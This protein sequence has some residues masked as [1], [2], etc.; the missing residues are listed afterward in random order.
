LVEKLSAKSIRWV[1]KKGTWE[2][3]DWL[4]RK[5]EG[6]EEAITHGSRLEKKLNIDPDD[7][8]MNPKLHEM[9]TLTELDTH[10]QKL[11]EKG[12]GALNLFLAEKYI[13]YMSPFAA[14]ILTCMGVIVSSRKTRGGMGLQVALGF[15][16]ALVY[17]AFFLFARGTAEVKGHNMLL[18]IWLPNIIFTAISLLLYRL[19]PK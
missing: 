18:T 7:F 4:N 1:E 8:S 16:L 5:I 14:I 13:R 10:I 15:V 2:F 11:R 17:I 12:T 19:T 9:L 3:K 6:L